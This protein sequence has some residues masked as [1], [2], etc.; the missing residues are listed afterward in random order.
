MSR[1]IRQPDGSV[2]L[3]TMLDGE[4]VMPQEE[5]EKRLR[6]QGPTDGVVGDGIVALGGVAKQVLDKLHKPEDEAP[7][8]P[9]IVYQRRN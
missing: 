2:H 8:I 6:N 9:G 7:R 4:Y 3:R 1:A 5:G